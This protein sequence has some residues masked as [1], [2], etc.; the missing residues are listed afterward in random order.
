MPADHDP[1][2]TLHPGVRLQLAFFSL[3]STDVQES[4]IAL[5]NEQGLGGESL[6]QAGLLP[7]HM[8]VGRFDG[9]G[10][11][12]YGYSIHP[13]QASSGPLRQGEKTP[14]RSEWQQPHTHADYLQEHG[15]FD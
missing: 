1:A 6:G 12:F 11:S 4:R 14:Q 7:G 2:L 9:S 13:P 3:G 8:S 15:G 5:P 10:D